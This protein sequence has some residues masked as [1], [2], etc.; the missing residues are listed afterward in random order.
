M[1]KTKRWYNAAEAADYL[2]LHVDSVRRLARNGQIPHRRLKGYQ[3]S[4]DMLDAF[5]NSRTKWQADFPDPMK[6][7]QRKGRPL[8]SDRGIGDAITRGLDQ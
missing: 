3:F 6:V 4:K 7:Q 5:L 8:D 2:G 1:A